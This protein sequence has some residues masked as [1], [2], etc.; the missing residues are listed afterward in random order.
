MTYQEFKNKYNG[1]YLDYD[2]KYGGQCWDL[3]QYYFTECLGIPS[4]VLSGCGLVSNMLYQPKRAVLD[5][6]FDEISIY[7]MQPGDV[8]IWEYGHIAIYDHW[9]KYCYFFSQNYPLGSNCHVQLIEEPGLHA[10]RIKG[11]VQI[12]PNVE[13][14][15]YKN[16]IEVKVEELNVRTN[17]S[18]KAN[19]LGH[20]NKG[21]YNFYQ[22]KDSDGYTWYNIAENQWV[23]YNKEWVEVLPM[24]KPFMYQ[25]SV[26]DI[27]WQ[28]W[29]REGEI[30]GTTGKAKHLEAIRIDCEEEVYAK[31]HIQDKGWVD[32][33]KINKDT[34]I[35][36]VGENKQLECICFKG[37]FKYRVHLQ[38]YGWTC[39]TEADGVSTLGSVGQNLS[40]EAIQIKK[41]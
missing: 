30:V 9:D 37:D 24:K 18:T 1:K 39:W 31:A 12:T 27:G 7:N 35:G 25:G 29:K 14:D 33:G 26:Q 11:A 10:F 3:G 19:S 28:D 21:F 36:T 32:Y 38:D 13:R 41:D 40:I 6:Y 20:A 16:Q 2:K 15:I 4:S 8:C 23:A 5:K 22:V 34:I 17:P